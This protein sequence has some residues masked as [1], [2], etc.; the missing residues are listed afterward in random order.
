M[1]SVFRISSQNQKYTYSWRLGLPIRVTSKV[2]EIQG[3]RANG[4]WQ[5]IFRTYHILPRGDPV[6]Q[7]ARDGDLDGLRQM[8]SSGKFSIFVRDH[9]GMT[10]LSVSGLSSYPLAGCF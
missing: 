1:S 7:F 2:F 5:W 9:L 3:K 6:F 10:L 8:L 4:G